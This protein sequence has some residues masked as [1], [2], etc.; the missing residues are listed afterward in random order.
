[1]HWS[2]D[3]YHAPKFTYSNVHL[4]PKTS[5]LWILSGGSC[6]SSVVSFSLHTDQDEINI[7]SLSVERRFF[8]SLSVNNDQARH[9]LFSSDFSDKK[10]GGIPNYSGFNR[11]IGTGHCNLLHP[12]IFHKHSNLL[13]KRRRNR[14]LIPFQSIQEQEKELLPLSGISIDIPIKGIFR[15]NSILAYFD[16]PRYRRKSSGITKYGKR[17]YSFYSLS[18]QAMHAY[19]KVLL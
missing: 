8:S 3:V 6:R 14:F 17:T 19:L 16:D 15:R 18:H 12:A 5:H 11:T 1:M 13:A 10:E 4:L 2:T 9:K 7:D